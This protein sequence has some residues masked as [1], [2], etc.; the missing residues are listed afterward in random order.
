MP[1]KHAALKQIRKDRVRQA[2]NQA[3]RSELKTM[4]KR[5]HDL[6]TTRKLDEAAAFIPQLASRFDR[7]AS[8]GI[9][10]RNT[11]SRSKSRLMGRLKRQRA[12]S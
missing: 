3:A 1:N 8:V 6:L 7:A 4:T 2:R 9:I 12:A 11:A 10:H 5:F